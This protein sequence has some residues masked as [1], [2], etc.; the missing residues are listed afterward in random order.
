MQSDGELLRRYAETR[1]EEAFAELVRRHLDLV[2]SAALRQV[3]GDA[4]LAQDVAQTVFADL[5]RKAE[6]LSGRAVLTGWLYTSTHFAAAKAVR[7]ERRRQAH[8][9][10][11]YAM[12]ELLSDPAPGPDWDH[13][14]PILDAVMHELNEDD[15]EAVL[16]RYFE[17]RQ[18]A[19]IGAK[20]GVSE[21]TARMRVERALEK[22]RAQLARRGVTTAA[23]ALSAALSAHAVQTAPVGLAVSVAAAAAI[24]GTAVPASTAIA[25]T[26]AI[27]MTT[28]QKTLITVTVAALAGAGIYEARQASQSRESA[29]TLQQENERLK[30]EN[31]ELANQHSTPATPQAPASDQQRELL[32][33]RGEVGVLRRQKDE[34]S[35]ALA[36]AQK[37]RTSS[38]A[39]T[40]ADTSL[41]E[42]PQTPNAATRDIFETWARGDWDTFFANFDLDGG[43]EMWDRAMNDEMKSHLAGMEVVNIGEPT[44]SFASNMWFVPYTVRFRDGTE[45]SLRLHV[46]QNPSTGRWILKGGF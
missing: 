2:Y 42:Y 32:R 19:E 38:N 41:E 13:V 36:A 30:A 23:T 46:A 26:K 45:K 9:Q 1:S 4:H 31:E 20:L 8:E 22:L 39:Q 5:A 18:H 21:N 34:L 33:L 29:Q 7:S 37:S 40:P 25:V 11:A 3:N 27:A 15:R 44:N 10:E 35:Q 24:T 12:R 43:R 28:L 6:A 16:L 14:R 17:R